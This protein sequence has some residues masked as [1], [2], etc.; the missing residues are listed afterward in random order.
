VGSL[1]VVVAKVTIVEYGD[2]FGSS[3]LTKLIAMRV[4][5]LDKEGRE[6]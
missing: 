5:L 6:Y 3:R 1:I 4:E 2:T